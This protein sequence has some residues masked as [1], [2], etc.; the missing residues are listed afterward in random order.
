MKS[1]LLAMSL[2]AALLAA[3]CTSPPTNSKSF[4]KSVSENPDHFRGEFIS[5]VGDPLWVQPDSMGRTLIHIYDNQTHE[6]AV[7]T[8]PIRLSLDN[9]YPH[10]WTQFLGR[11]TGATTGTNPNGDTFSAIGVT[12][13][14]IRW[15][16]GTE[17]NPAD[18]AIFNQWMAGRLN[19]P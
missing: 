8:F 1:S 16:R 18:E 6:F 14:A 9:F 10:D 13:I 17:F 15:K 3:G 2:A 7:V 4:G 11:V 12:G 19:L 5:F